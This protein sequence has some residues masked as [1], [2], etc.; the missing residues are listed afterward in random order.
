MESSW[1]GT[2]FELLQELPVLFTVKNPRLVQKDFINAAEREIW[3]VWTHL[4]KKKKGGAIG[5]IFRHIVLCIA[6]KA[7]QILLYC[8]C[9]TSDLFQT[10][11]CHWLLLSPLCHV[12]A[13]DS[14]IFLPPNP[15]MPPF[16]TSSHF[17]LLLLHKC[18]FQIYFLTH[19]YINSALWPL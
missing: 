9:N 3:K 6:K 4:K 10:N 14:L 18:I 11:F 1:E 19:L 2:I 15:H 8:E 7:D 17:L 5:L 13:A 12:F 16:L